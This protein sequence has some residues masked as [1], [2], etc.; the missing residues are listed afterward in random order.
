MFLKRS[1]GCN[2]VPTGVANNVIRW[3]PPPRR[4][5]WPTPWG[6]PRQGTAPRRGRAPAACAPSARRTCACFR[7]CAP[8]Y[9]PTCSCPA[10]SLLQSC[11]VA[12]QSH[13]SRRR[14]A[15]SMDGADRRCSGARAPR[16]TGRSTGEQWT[17]KSK[18]GRGGRPAKS[19]ERTR[20]APPSSPATTLAGWRQAGRR[21][22]GS[23]GAIVPYHTPTTCNMPATPSLHLRFPPCT[24]EVIPG[25]YGCSRLPTP[26]PA[27]ALFH[28]PHQFAPFLEDVP[29][30]NT[31]SARAD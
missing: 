27:L 23:R 31:S 2:W 24:Y 22:L 7:W 26:L 21:A 12:P 6:T 8:A 9:L 10:R 29:P 1:Q 16:T 11:G 20:A 18:R 28:L 15:A 5:S 19:R 3:N 13:R 17:K 30:S 14:S 4:A 25:P